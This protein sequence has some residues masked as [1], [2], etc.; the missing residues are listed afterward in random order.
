VR[1]DWDERLGWTWDLLSEDPARREHA[2]RILDQ[3]RL[4]HSEALQR[5]NAVWLQPGS[6][7]LFA[8][9]RQTMSGMLPHA[10][11]EDQPSRDEMPTW[12]GLPYLLLYLRW[13]VFFPNEWTWHAKGWG[14]K[15][16]IL[17]ELTRVAD[18]LPDRHLRL[19]SDLIVRVVARPQRLGDE[20]YARLAR[21]LPRHLLQA[22]LTDLAADPDPVT[23]R[24]AGYLLLLLDDILSGKPTFAQWQ[25]YLRERHGGGEHIRVRANAVP[26]WYERVDTILIRCPQCA[27]MGTV[28]RDPDVPR[29]D[30]STWH[31]GCGSC[32]FTNSRTTR[33]ANGRG[34]PDEASEAVFG[35]PLWLQARCRDGNLLSADHLEQLDRIERYLLARV[36]LRGGGAYGIV[37]GQ[38][39]LPEW[40]KPA[41]RRAE[42]LDAIGRLRET[43]A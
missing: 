16:G 21:V 4:V 36:D 1:D 27:A 40:M 39:H 35:Y 6:D 2:H 13:E 31:A 30:G 25:R 5:Y 38:T 28:R 11:W 14:A 15:T 12:P 3:A 24:R 33:W 41:T 7:R 20:W 10:L 19:L 9:Y 34:H 43:V 29:A 37:P 32:T 42:V 26:A 17:R 8:E 23:R 22:R 18:R